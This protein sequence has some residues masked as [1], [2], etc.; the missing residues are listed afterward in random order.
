MIGGGFPITFEAIQD[1]EAPKHAREYYVYSSGRAALYQILKYLRVKQ[2]IGKILL[3]DYLCSSV[4][5]PVKE[6]GLNYAFYPL[7][8]SLQ[9][10][11]DVFPLLYS[12]DSAVL[13][14]NYYGLQ[15][16]SEQIGFIRSIDP[17][18]VIIEDDVQAYFEFKKDLGGADF[19]FTSLRKTFPIPDGG[20]VKTQHALPMI[21]E[22][23]TFG[24][25]KAAAGLMKSIRTGNFDDKVYL[26]ISEDAEKMI[27][28]E[29]DKGISMIAEKLY[30]NVDESFV[31]E[32][33][34]R[35]AKYLVSEMDRIGLKPLLPL[36]DDKVPLFVPVL[37]P[38][39]NKVRSS[40]F[41]HDVFCP[42]H[43]PL[44]GLD[45]K[46]GKEMA[47]HELSLVIDQRYDEKDMGTIILLLKK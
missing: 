19:K 11:Q 9:L 17:K 42:V 12:N 14:I 36:Q 41:D 21:H 20:L 18:A 29:V 46:K 43:W 25:Y 7:N 22:R 4:M 39:R 40:M 30:A 2:D 34:I 27:D 15:D 5:M 38:N 31:K 44:D 37:L 33:R 10:R 1:A 35:N 32:R 13:L 28:H 23:N 47:E 26:N 3:P 24:Q 16:L 6:L 45:V 8:E